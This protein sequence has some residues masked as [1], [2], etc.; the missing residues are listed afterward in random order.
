M[1]KTFIKTYNQILMSP[2][3]ITDKFDKTFIS[4]I[5]NFFESREEYEKCDLIK[6]FFD[7]NP[8]NII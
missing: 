8:K 5:F 4:G 1:D 7:K 2:N 3:K 6:S